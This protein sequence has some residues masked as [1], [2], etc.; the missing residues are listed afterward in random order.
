MV[1]MKTSLETQTIA[2]DKHVDILSQLT[3][4]NRMMAH[5]LEVSAQARSMREED[6]R[7]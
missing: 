3:E 1:T 7:K 5:A 6:E 2:N 4:N